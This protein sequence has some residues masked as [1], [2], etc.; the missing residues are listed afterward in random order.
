MWFEEQVHVLRHDD[1]GPEGDA[2]RL[3]DTVQ[4]FDEP[5]AGSVIVEKWQSFGTGKR[6]EMDVTR[7]VDESP[8]LLMH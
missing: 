5:A 6:K 1:I 3:S 7:F 8:P 2:L 4:R